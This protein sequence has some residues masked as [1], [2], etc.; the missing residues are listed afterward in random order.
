MDR[1]M[2]YPGA[3]PRSVDVLSTN[4]NSMMAIGAFAQAII[5]SNM[6]V[7]GLQIAPTTPAS[8]AVTIGTGSIYALDQVDASAYS[9]LGTNSAV[10]TKQGLL[11]SPALLNITPPPTPGYSQVYLVEATYSDVDAGGQVL[12]YYNSGNPQQPYAGPAN[13]G[14][15][16]FT[17]RQGVCT[18]SLKAGV[19][20]PT[21]SQSAPSPDAGYV[22]LWLITVANGQTTI[23]SANWKQY[24]PSSFIQALGAVAGI[25]IGS[26]TSYFSAGTYTYTPS[27]SGYDLVILTGAGGGGGATSN[28]NAFSGASGGSGETRWKTIPRVAGQS[29][30]VIIGAGAGEGV[31]V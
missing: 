25:M 28:T 26:I 24:T 12:P 15:S 8:L 17:V 9:T 14:V 31:G 19:A 16:Q 13:S 18:I 7:A 20:A 5:G 2:A 30:T 6:S 4:L 22:G 11:L 3:L 27:T 1:V 29:T 10:I 23:T 21:G